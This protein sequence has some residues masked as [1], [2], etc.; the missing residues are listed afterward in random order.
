MSLLID[1]IVLSGF[2]TDCLLAICPTNLS[3][4]FEKATTDGIVL[5]PSV[6]AITVGFPPSI[7][8]THELVV[9]KSIPIIFDIF[10]SSLFF[11]LIIMSKISSFPSLRQRRM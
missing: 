8:E 2:V 7:T 5:A 4:L 10:Y 9:P 6:L 3:P 1:M 11:I